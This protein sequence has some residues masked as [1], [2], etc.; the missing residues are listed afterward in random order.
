MSPP[1]PGVQTLAKGPPSLQEPAAVIAV[2]AAQRQTTGPAGIALSYE[3][4]N[5]VMLMN[6]PN[7][8]RQWRTIIKGSMWCIGFYF[9]ACLFGS[10]LFELYGP[11]P[12]NLGTPYNT[13]WCVAQL[14]GLKAELEN[15]VLEEVAAFNDETTTMKRWQRWFTPWQARVEM[16]GTHCEVLTQTTLPQAYVMLKSLGGHYQHLVDESTREPQTLRTAIDTTIT[17]LRQ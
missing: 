7:S 14:S 10:I 2:R 8:D 16:S 17:A 12:Q 3:W 5:K 4:G 6:T 15:K 11:P 13:Y 1:L 9:L